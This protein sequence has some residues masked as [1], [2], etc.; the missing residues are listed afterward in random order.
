MAAFHILAV[1]LV[2]DGVH[3]AAVTGQ[4]QLLRAAGDVISHHA[5]VRT[6]R[7]YH[8]VGAE[9]DGGHRVGL[10]LELADEV[11]VVAAG[12]RLRLLGFGYYMVYAN[13]SQTYKRGVGTEGP[14]GKGRRGIG[15]FAFFEEVWWVGGW[16]WRWWV[17]QTWVDS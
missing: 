15:G 4:C 3:R 12:S 2:G 5:A 8:A 14:R 16:G 9:G 10:T 11:C 6:D 7:Q 17:G 1:W 13:K